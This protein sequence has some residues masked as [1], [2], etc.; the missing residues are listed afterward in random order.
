M[1]VDDGVARSLVS[2][3]S[4]VIESLASVLPSASSPCS[5]AA[6]SVSE[7]TSGVEAADSFFSRF[8]LLHFAQFLLISFQISLFSF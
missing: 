6:P 5:S 3:S 4:I 1:L 2:K 8:D 7:T